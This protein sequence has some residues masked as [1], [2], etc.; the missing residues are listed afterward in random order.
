M[1]Q[2]R[3]RK[4]G[5]FVKKTKWQRAFKAGSMYKGKPRYTRVR[6]KR[7]A[8]SVDIQQERPEVIGAELADMFYGG[9]ESPEE[10]EY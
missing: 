3:D 2:Y 9:E 10:A 1:A 5:R 8:R 7:K 6:A 4:T